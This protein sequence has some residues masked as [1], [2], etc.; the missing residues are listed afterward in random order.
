MVQAQ[1]GV[2][3]V[4]KEK[5]ILQKK[6]ETLN[7]EKSLLQGKYDDLVSS[8]DVL[9]L[10]NRVN[11]RITSGIDIDRITRVVDDLKTDRQCSKASQKR[12][13]VKT[14]LYKGEIKNTNVSFEGSLFA[15]T[16][17]GYSS[18]NDEEKPESWFDIE[19]HISVSFNT[20]NGTEVVKQALP[21]EKSIILNDKEYFF[22]IYESG[23]RGFV[24]IEEHSCNYP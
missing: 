12:F 21:I 24:S 5:V 22:E 14:P 9:T 1:E 18:I 16:A 13:I 15:I 4:Q 11:V 3:K 2:D 20:E 8:E 23:T 19:K 6:I 17:D 7:I 10:F